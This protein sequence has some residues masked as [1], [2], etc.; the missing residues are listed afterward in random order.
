MMAIML[1]VKWWY[2]PG[3]KW[4]WRGVLVDKLTLISELFSVKEMITTLFAPFRQTF[5]GKAEGLEIFRAMAD[6]LISRFVGFLVRVLLLAVAMLA[7]TLTLIISLTL[8]VLW[9][10][11]PLLPVIS[12]ILFVLKVGV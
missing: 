11:L 5:V 6:K 8:L 4:A 3:L 12:I 1:L 7:I 2:G 9:P 10:L